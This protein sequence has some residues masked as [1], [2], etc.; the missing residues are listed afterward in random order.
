MPFVLAPN[1]FDMISRRIPQHSPLT[2][3]AQADGI[4]VGPDSPESFE[5]VFWQTFGKRL[6]ASAGYGFKP[7][8]A[9]TD[10]YFRDYRQLVIR[11]SKSSL[12]DDTVPRY[13]SK[14]NVNVIRLAELCQQPGATVLLV[15]R[16]PAT[17]ASSLLNQHLRFTALQASDPFGRKYMGWLGH[18]EFGLDHLPLAPI[19]D[20]L[21]SGLSSDTLDYWL[22]YWILLYRYIDGLRNVP[23]RL[24]NYEVMCL[25]PIEFYNEL[26]RVLDVELPV[27]ADTSMI[28]SK[29]T[30][31]DSAAFNPTFLITALD[32]YKDLGKD[33]RNII[34][35]PL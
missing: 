30:A 19:N 21:N 2:E 25:Q 23:F 17:T 27:A 5:E 1:L 24:V 32:L 14:N 4:M 35:L 31:F 8:S 3:R 22:F 7:M 33:V 12:P 15:Y 29:S 11:H 10:T 20:L 13:L 9:D 18:H 28:W 26:C 6:P 34:P 16:H